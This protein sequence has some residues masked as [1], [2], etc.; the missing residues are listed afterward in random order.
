[1]RVNAGA[2]T[3]GARV[4]RQR[5]LA[6]PSLIRAAGDVLSGPRPLWVLLS[7]SLACAVA[8][9]AHICDWGFLAGTSPYWNAP[10]G[11]VPNSW[12]DISTAVSGYDY[13]VRA[14]WNFPIFQVAKLGAPAGTNIIFTDS[15]PLVALAGRLWYRLTGD[16]INPYGG[17]MALCFAASALS[18][19]GLVAALGQRSVAAAL[20]ATVSGLCLPALMFRWGHMSLMGQWQ[21]PLALTLYFASRSPG[22]GA[23]LLVASALLSVAAL[24]THTY[25]F[26]MVTGILGATL[27]QAAIDRRLSPPRAALIGVLALAMWAGLIA[28]SGQAANRG[29]FVAEGFGQYSTNLL[30]P[31][32]PQFSALFPFMGGRIVDGTNEQYEGFCYL[33]AGTILL[34]LMT[35]PWL[36]RALP[37]AF[38]RHACLSLLLLAFTLFAV[39]NQV[40]AGVWH[41]ATIPLPEPL[42][43]LA[44]MFR[45]SGRFVWP[46]VYLL[47]A[48][49]I[50][51]A[52]ALLGRAGSA[53]LVLAALV[54][55]ADTS[56]LQ[57]ALAARIATPAAA[58]LA[59]RAWTSAIRQHTFVSVLP[60][61]G[62]LSDPRDVLA[63]TA[64]ELELLAS[65]EDVPTNTVYAARHQEHCDAPQDSPLAPGELRVYLP[66]DSRATLPADARNACA[67]TPDLV[68]CSARL[69]SSGAAALIAAG[70]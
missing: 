52:P 46:A 26:V 63:Q 59:E 51:A 56:P 41:V 62:C 38:R 61:Y 48:V 29:S 13:F 47:S 12:A 23:G 19:T 69:G 4:G 45:A 35:L 8:F 17:W 3:G 36:R 53:V 18:M 66:R 7:L 16:L 44:S 43:K 39:S 5:S 1:M 20:A 64:V 70:R 31:V 50:V 33:G 9:V 21:I 10:R 24:W 14:P 42:L 55:F 57:S 22:R 11:L 54:Q 37:A 25:L 65:R 30:S 15:I 60:P 27:L 2:H 28:L 40:Y 58:P 6:A 68:V 49:V 34:I 67:A 32:I